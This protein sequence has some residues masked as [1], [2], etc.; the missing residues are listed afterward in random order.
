MFNIY[1]WECVSYSLCA[2][3]R[4]KSCLAQF[5]LQQLNISKNKDGS[6]MLLLN[7]SLMTK[8]GLFIEH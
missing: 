5:H 8:F 3:L 4:E 2:C 1:E 6:D 7:C